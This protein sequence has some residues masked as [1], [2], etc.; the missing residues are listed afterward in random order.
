MKPELTQKDI[1]KIIKAIKEKMKQSSHWEILI[2]YNEGTM[3]IK[4]TIRERIKEK[5][6]EIIKNTYPFN[7][8]K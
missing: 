8:L 5:K 1:D 4:S 7:S 2:I 3:D 6:K